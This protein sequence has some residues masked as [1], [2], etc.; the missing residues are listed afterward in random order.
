MKSIIL[1]ITILSSIIFSKN[2]VSLESSFGYQSEKTPLNL[3]N[4]S[5]LFNLNEHHEIFSGFGGIIFGGSL[6]VGYKYYINNFSKP[7]PYVSI[8]KHSGSYFDSMSVL[9]GISPSVGYSIQIREKTEKKAGIFHQLRPFK[10]TI[11]NFGVSY[12][13]ILKNTMR[14]FEGKNTLISPFLN[15]SLR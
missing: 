3:F 5:L 6:F 15:F 7:S 9:E 14:D 1:S 12:V 2:I 10:K 11:L 4:A 13:F 8:S